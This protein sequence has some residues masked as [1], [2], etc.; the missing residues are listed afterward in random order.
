MCSIMDQFTSMFGKESCETGYR[1]LEYEY[2][3]I[4]LDGYKLVLF[5]SNVFLNI[6][7]I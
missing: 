2:N 6:F 7:R 3:T 4:K 5:N 1:S